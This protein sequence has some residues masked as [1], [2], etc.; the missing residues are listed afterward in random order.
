MNL[1]PTSTLKAAEI[2]LN[3]VIGT[4]IEVVGFVGMQ[5]YT[6]GSI[7]LVLRVGPIMAFTR[8]HVINSIV[9]Y[10]LLLRRPWLYKHKLVPSI[11]HQCVKGRFNGKPIRILANH[12]LFN[13][14][15][16]HY[17]EA[18]FYD[19]FTLCGEDAMSKPVRIPLHY[20][21]ANFY[22]EF[23]L[24]GE[25]AMSKPVR[26]PLPDWE[27]IEEEPKVDLRGILDQKK[28][29]RECREAFGSRAQLRC[30]QVQLLNWASWLSI[31]MVRGA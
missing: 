21:E 6:I 23:T 29:K 12:T 14:S 26:I 9:S 17:F 10:H 7:Q 3:R 1:I 22:D 15:K 25:D 20:F 5:K 2:S 8:F 18:N 13:L 16:A 4:P 11:Y 30:A 19:E 27:V 31:M 24:C 28:K